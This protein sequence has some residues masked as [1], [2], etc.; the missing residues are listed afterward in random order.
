MAP[1][2]RS[3]PANQPR[4]HRRRALPAASRMVFRRPGAA[5][6]PGDLWL[7]GQRAGARR[8]HL[9]AGISRRD[10]HPD[11]DRPAGARAGRVQRGAAPGRHAAAEL[12]PRRVGWVEARPVSRTRHGPRL[13]VR[14]SRP[15][16][17]RAPRR[18][19]FDTRPPTRQTT[20]RSP[21]SSPPKGRAGR[22]HASLAARRRTSTS[23]RRRRRISG[24]ALPRK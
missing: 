3:D 12:P 11:P 24:I 21:P 19:P 4:H 10:P 16:H 13:L 23:Q 22:Y 5:A 1:R 8:A 15:V 2:S 17:R 6:G 18:T 9:E 14:L 7:G 20:S